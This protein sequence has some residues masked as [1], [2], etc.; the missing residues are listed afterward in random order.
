MPKGSKNKKNLIYG[1]IGGIAAVAV[2]AV[3]I[4]VIVLNS[5][6]ALNDD[7]FKSDGSKYVLTVDF[8]EGQDESEG[9]DELAPI[10]SHAVYRY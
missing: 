9:T 6:P 8:R 7:F 5:K 4:V 10:K 1:I 3:I 2:I